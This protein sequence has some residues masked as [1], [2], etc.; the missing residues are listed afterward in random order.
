VLTDLLRQKTAAM[1]KKTTI[2]KT[3]PSTGGSYFPMANM[4]AILANPMMLLRAIRPLSQRGN[5]L[6][7][8]TIQAII[9]KANAHINPLA[10]KS[11]V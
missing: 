1:A 4:S 10:S 8:Q 9:S 7:D 2:N 5:S 3:S 6:I 11:E